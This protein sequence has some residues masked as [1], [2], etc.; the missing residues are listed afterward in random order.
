LAC[1]DLKGN[2]ENKREPGE[3]GSQGEQGEQGEQEPPIDDDVLDNYLLRSSIFNEND[4]INILVTIDSGDNSTAIGKNSLSHKDCNVVIGDGVG[5]YGSN[6]V[7]IFAMPT[8][9]GTFHT[10]NLFD[11]DS[12][13][14]GNYSTTSV[15]FGVNGL[16]IIWDSSGVKIKVGDRE[17]LINLEVGPGDGPNG[18]DATG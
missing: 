3:Q 18:G 8:L 14:I 12:V 9:S 10:V 2:L 15:I 11:N 7:S 4:T 6:I 17:G 5:I 13:Y 16:T 1:K